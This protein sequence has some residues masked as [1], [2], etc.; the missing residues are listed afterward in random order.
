MRKVLVRPGV[1][2]YIKENGSIKKI[3]YYNENGV[4]HRENLPAYTLYQELYGCEDWCPYYIKTKK[5]YAD[6]HITKEE[7][8]NVEETITRKYEYNGDIVFRTTYYY[9][10]GNIKKI[11]YIN[12]DRQYHREDGPAVTIYNEDGSILAKQYYYNG[13]KIANELQ[14]LVLTN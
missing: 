13:K 8:Y 12:T 3:E 6:G 9:D 7:H 11:A 2:H 10:N 14:L 5:W 4:L 1:F